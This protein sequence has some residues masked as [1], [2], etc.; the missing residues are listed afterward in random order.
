MTNGSLIHRVI[1]I[2]QKS[3][4]KSCN[5]GSSYLGLCNWDIRARVHTRSNY[6]GQEQVIT[7]H[8]IQILWDV[9][10]CHCVSY[11]FWRT[12]SRTSWPDTAKPSNHRQY[13]FVCVVMFFF[14]HHISQNRLCKVSCADWAF[15]YII[16]IYKTNLFHVVVSKKP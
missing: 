14:Q 15:I 2:Q 6:Q 4:L 11:L 9:L 12:S 5:I 13:V 7:F 10:T 3:T 8:S 1:W 16:W